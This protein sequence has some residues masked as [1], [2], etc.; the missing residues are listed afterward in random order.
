MPPGAA[1]W[2]GLEG[3]SMPLL[4][5]RFSAKGKGSVFLAKDG[6]LLAE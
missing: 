4:S 2:D 3:A 6:A 5:L 1:L